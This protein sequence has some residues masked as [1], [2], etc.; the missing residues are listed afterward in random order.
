MGETEYLIAL[1]GFSGFGPKRVS[2]LLSFFGSAKKAWMA[3]A[4]ELLALGLKESTVSRFLVYK[5]SFDPE[6]YFGTLKKLGIQ[7][8]TIKDPDYPSNLKQIDDAPSVLYIKGEIKP[9]DKLAVAIVGARKATSYGREVTEKLTS[10]LTLSGVTIVSGLARGIDTVAHKVALSMQGRT[11]GVLAGGLDSVYPPENTS[12]AA[13]IAKKGAV[14][15]EFPLGI[16]AR[17]E[18]FPTRNR[19]VSGLSLGVVVVEGAGRSGTLLTASNA[20]DQGRE[21]FA[22]PGPIT[23]SGS[24]APNWLIKNGAKVVTKAEDIL[25]ELKIGKRGKQIEA[26]EILPKSQEEEN[27]LIF[28]EREPLHLDEIV[29]LTGKDT[30]FV[31]ATLSMMEI[32]GLVKNLGGMVF[33]KV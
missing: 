30:G 11:I 27:L 4:E 19:I 25:D 17:P 23:S 9:Q 14:V 15:S 8:K 10:L 28:L 2:L 13:E 7:A 26:S 21:V 5:K 12:L 22:I 16:P 31:S 33:K 24:E 32:K 6:K 29:R 3:S 20:A 1:A 18:N